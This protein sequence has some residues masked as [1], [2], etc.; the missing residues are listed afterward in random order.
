MRDTP[1]TSSVGSL[2]VLFPSIQ[3][4][5]SAVPRTQLVVVVFHPWVVASL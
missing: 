2:C 5:A 1:V 3:R 4:A